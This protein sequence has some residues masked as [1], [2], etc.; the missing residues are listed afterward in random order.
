MIHIRFVLIWKEASKFQSLSGSE[1]PVVEIRHEVQL[2]QFYKRH[3]FLVETVTLIFGIRGWLGVL[4]ELIQATV[5]S[6]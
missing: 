3:H 4:A 5:V 2:L 6:N 1:F